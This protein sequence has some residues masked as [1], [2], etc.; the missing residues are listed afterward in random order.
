MVRLRF[1]IPHN[2]IDAFNY[3]INVTPVTSGPITIWIIS[4]GLPGHYNP[5]LGIVRAIERYRD[6]HHETIVATQRLKMLRPLM[7]YLVNYLPELTPGLLRLFYRY[8][9]LPQE[10]PDLVISGGGN[11]LFFNAAL[12]VKYKNIKN[13]YSGTL[14]HYNPKRFFRIFTVV[15]LES[16]ANN[17]VLDLPA[18]NIPGAPDSQ[19]ESPTT[20]VDGP[21]YCL[22]VGGEG[23]GYHYTEDDWARLA[24]SVNRLSLEFGVQWLITTSRRTGERAEQILKET[25]PETVI[26]ESVWFSKQPAKVVQRFLASASRVFCTEDSLTMVSEAIFSGK[27][28]C[29]LLPAS[30][31]ATENDRLALEH[32]ASKGYIQRIKITD[33]ASTTRFNDAN[34]PDIDRL[35]RS[36]YEALELQQSAA[37]RP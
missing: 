4:D 32:Y 12:G 22:L 36:I 35:Q 2:P 37:G 15:P 30:V 33:L 3:E 9:S 25:I 27:P 19:T 29:T 16:A 17:V 21:C 8:N 5:S 6:V 20:D 26:R 18:A 34:P 24:D 13:V 11:T 7:R 31:S 14:K 10:R 1:T 23:G 28:V